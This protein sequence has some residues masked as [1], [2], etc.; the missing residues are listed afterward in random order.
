MKT[1]H[2]TLFMIA[3][4]LTAGC[5]RGPERASVTGEVRVGGELLESGSITFVPLGGNGPTAGAPI[6][7]GR[8][9]VGRE[10]G[11]IVGKNRVEVRGDRKTG[12][13]RPHPFNRDEQMDEVVEAVPREYNERSTLDRDVQR[14]DNEF[15]FDLPSTAPQGGAKVH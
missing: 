15:N 8:Y 14:G 11:V 7:K 12:R 13:R 6:V 10:R 9:E 4:L 5:A 1:L 2:L 3:A